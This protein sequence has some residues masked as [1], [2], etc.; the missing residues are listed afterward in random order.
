MPELVFLIPIAAIVFPILFAIV[1]VL[2]RHQ[3]KMAEILHGQPRLQPAS[4]EIAQLR[5]EVAKVNDRLNQVL[6]SL[7]RGSAVRQ[8]E[9]QER[10]GNQRET[11]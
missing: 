8:E 1:M 6:L 10:L 5:T 7:E 2:V 4:D 9:I 11:V 3:Q